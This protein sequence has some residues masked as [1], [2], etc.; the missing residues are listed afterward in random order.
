[1]NDGARFPNL[2][3][4]GAPK[5][6]TTSLAA[7]LSH[8]PDIFVPVT[9]EPVVFGTDLTSAA[10]RDPA[11]TAAEIYGAWTGE[12]F[13]LDASTHYF[14]SESA[15]QEIAAACAEPRVYMLVRNPAD[16][17]NSMYHQLRF[18]EAESLTTLEESL[19][20]ETHRAN[21]LLPIR[22]GFP[23]N[24]LYSRIFAYSKNIP[25]FERSIGSSRTRV[26]LF[27][28]LVADPRTVTR[29]IFEDL[30]IDPE[31]AERIDYSPKNAAK[32]SRSRWIHQL[33][34]YPPGWAG[35]TSKPLL[36]KET[37]MRIR[38]WLKRANAVPHKNPVLQHETRR[39]LNDQFRAEVNWLSNYLGRDLSYWIED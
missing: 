8:H 1:M 5:C 36:S 12:R 6:G 21:S 20:A 24:R 32:R 28:D 22:F 27:D 10:P 33:A 4:A 29:S 18:N 2:Y 26:I 14:F 19:D 13:A 38:E 16:A 7:W 3:L 9:K 39:R 35:K 17:V 34:S 15:A 23:E 30:N 25:R 11:A 31:V 37:R